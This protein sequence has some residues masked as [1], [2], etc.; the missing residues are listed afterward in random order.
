[1]A[2]RGHTETIQRAVPHAGKIDWSLYPGTYPDDL[3]TIKK[4]VDTFHAKESKIDLLFNNANVSHPP[5]GR[6]SKHIVELQLATNCLG[7]HLCIRLL[8]PYLIAAAA[9]ASP[10]SVRVNWISNKVLES[11]RQKA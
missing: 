7:P 5:V 10:V 2:A 9:T 11:P 8:L 4:T 1:M 6:I 3:T